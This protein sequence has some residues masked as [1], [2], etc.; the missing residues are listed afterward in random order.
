MKRLPVYLLMLVVTTLMAQEPAETDATT[1]PAAVDA[2]EPCIPAEELA[3]QG[4]GTQENV[5]EAVICKETD[6]EAAPN[7]AMQAMEDASDIDPGLEALD[8]NDEIVEATADEV[9][10]PDDEI[11]ED[12]PISLPSDI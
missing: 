11:H 3:A 1:E 2:V 5:P 10:R 4:E 9:F 6:P 8:E 7:D 12:Y